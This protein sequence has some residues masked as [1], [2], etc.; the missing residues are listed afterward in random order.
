MRDFLTP[1]PIVAIDFD[2][3][4]KPN[5]DI[6]DFSADIPEKTKEGLKRLKAA[7][8]HLVLWTSRHDF[9]LEP[10]INYLQ[11]QGVYSFFEAINDNIPDLWFTT[12]RKIFAHY[13][14]DDLAVGWPGFEKA[15]E[16]IL[17]DIEEAKRLNIKEERIDHSKL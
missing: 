15:V 2:G 1:E 9:K 4:L 10:A 17:S 7:G 16:I 6:C 3:T 12:S 14:M 5:N 8:C 11:Y 13:Y